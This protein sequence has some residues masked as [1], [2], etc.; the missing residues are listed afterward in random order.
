MTDAHTPGPWTV[1]N[2]HLGV[3]VC[4]TWD[5]A[6]CGG[7]DTNRSRDEEVANARLIAAAPDLL[8]A[9]RLA[10]TDLYIK[11]DKDEEADQW[12]SVLALQ[13]AILKATTANAGERG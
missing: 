4:A 9:C 13:A 2:T 5:V 10:L 7:F 1:F 11:A 6:H 3:G 8:E 12:S